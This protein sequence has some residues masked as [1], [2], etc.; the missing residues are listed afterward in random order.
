[1]KEGEGHG[2]ETERY[3]PN[4]VAWVRFDIDVDLR[5][6][7]TWNTK[8][9]F[10]YLVVNCYAASG[11]SGL[12]E[13][14]STTPDALSIASSRRNQVPAVQCFPR[15]DNNRLMCR[16]IVQGVDFTAGN[17]TGG[18]SIYGEHFEDESFAV[19][20]DKPFLLSIANTGPNT[21]GSL[22]FITCAPTPH[23][24][25]K[26]VV[27]GEVITGKSAVQNI[28]TGTADV[29]INPVVIAACGACGA[30]G[31]LSL[32]MD[33]T[34]RDRKYEEEL[35]KYAEALRYNLSV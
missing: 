22:F 29:P 15:T 5:S 23:L 21:T 27:F 26:H 34:P 3:Q 18:D 7:W 10:A 24:D 14:R 4:E 8:E 25:G 2:S 13:N 11:A 35:K 12:P 9:V 31:E 16:F 30:C 1:M 20:H 19:N 28:G 17:G 6:T 33:D 32:G